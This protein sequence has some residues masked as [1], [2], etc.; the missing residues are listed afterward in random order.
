MTID[1]LK[2]EFTVYWPH[3][4]ADEGVAVQP[5]SVHLNPAEAN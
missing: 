2:Y 5:S 4:D 1:T 3:Y